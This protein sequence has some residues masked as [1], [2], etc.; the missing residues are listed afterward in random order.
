MT[1]VHL[2][3]ILAKEFGK[4]MSFKVRRPKDV[5]QAIDANRPNFLKRV[6]DLAREGIHYNIIVDGKS[7]KE[8][9]ELNITKEV[10]KIDI[11]PTIVG[12][13]PAIAIVGAIVAIAGAA[14]EAAS[15]IQ[16]GVMLL[17][18][19][20]QMMLTPKP[21]MERPESNISPM[22]ESFSFSSKA[23]LVQQGIPVPVG[24]GRLRVGS[25]VIQ[26]T[27]KSFPQK[28]TQDLAMETDRISNE[29]VDQSTI[30]SYTNN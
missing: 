14:A 12:H 5:F 16:I 1:T 23:N 25:A 9:E 27:I 28:Y 22:K 8:P 6:I 4:E 7:I 21:K 20:L 30:S 19:G 11:I 2:H 15:I 29:V 18:I 10:N 3:G 24:Y 17:G 26:S 13:G